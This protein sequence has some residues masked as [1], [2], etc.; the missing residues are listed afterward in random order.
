MKTKLVGLTLGMALTGICLLSGR[1]NAFGTAVVD[2]PTNATTWNLDEDYNIHA[3]ADFHFT[4][5]DPKDVWGAR[6]VVYAYWTPAN[7]TEEEGELDGF[8]NNPGD[9]YV[10]DT[11]T[12][13]LSINVPV[14]TTE[15]GSL[16]VSAYAYEA[17][18]TEGFA[19][20]DYDSGYATVG[21]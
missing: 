10:N 1:A 15:A 13:D 20:D 4:M 3:H 2:E 19:L 11:E 16:D 18:P 9:A 12:H 8:P 17:A 21:C 7:N 14:H 6:L 5:N